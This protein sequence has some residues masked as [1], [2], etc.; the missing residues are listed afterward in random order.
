VDAVERTVRKALKLLV[1][2]HFYA[3]VQSSGKTKWYAPVLTPEELELIDVDTT[4]KGSSR[5]KRRHRQTANA[6]QGVVIDNDTGETVPHEQKE[7]P[8]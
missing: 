5:S 1:K 8:W 3:E 7:T 4:Y 2:H 6:T